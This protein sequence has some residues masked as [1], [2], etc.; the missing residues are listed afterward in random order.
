MLSITAIKA[1]TDNYIW[2]IHSPDGHCA[3]V[4]PGD[5]K[6]VEEFLASKALKLSTI[7]ITHHHF[8][9]VGGVEELRRKHAPQVIGPKNPQI[10]GISQAVSDG[11]RITLECLG[12]ELEVLEVPGHTLDH[13]AYYAA[14]S[15]WL[16]CG[17]T[18]FHC[19]CGRLFEGSP[20]Q[21]LHSLNKLAALP[22]A[23]KLYCT[24]EYT[25]ANMAF[26]LSVEP[27]NQALIEAHQA[28]QKLRANN[29]ATLP[30]SIAEQKR[31]NPFLRSAN[32]QLAAVVAEQ[33]GTEST[34]LA[35]F[36]ALRADK[37]RF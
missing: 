34:P 3:V 15:G 4:D 27:N 28:A 21:M 35:V 22:D 10:K 30:S 32:P 13:I 31:I 25:L 23:T 18:L 36:T 33:H 20:E 29:L 12:L 17:D 19:G 8:D 26:A 37:D 16:F 1:F 14:A 24:H 9:H 7:L 5:A 6:P 11:D 2:A